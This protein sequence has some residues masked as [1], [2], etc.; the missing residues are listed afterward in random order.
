VTALRDESLRTQHD[1]RNALDP[2]RPAALAAGKL[3]RQ[4]DIL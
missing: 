3:F 4:V 1:R 2:H